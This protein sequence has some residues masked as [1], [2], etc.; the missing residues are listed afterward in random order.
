VIQVTC[1]CDQGPR[2]IRN[3][4]V[5]W[6]D[7]PQCANDGGGLSICALRSDDTDA[8]H[9]QGAHGTDWEHHHAGLYQTAKNDG[10]KPGVRFLARSKRGTRFRTASLLGGMRQGRRQFCSPWLGRDQG[11]RH[12]RWRSSQDRN[13]LS[14]F[15]IGIT[16]ATLRICLI[17]L[18]TL[19]FVIL[20]LQTREPDDRLLVYHLA[21]TYPPAPDRRLQLRFRR[22]S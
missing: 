9:S 6:L 13:W 20:M 16:A 11:R 15:T 4:V 19:N 10:G 12:R 5:R 21:F 3:S 8:R 14:V 2:L 17:P 1:V 18:L 22:S 7:R